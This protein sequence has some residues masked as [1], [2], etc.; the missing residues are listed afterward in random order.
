[1]KRY[2]LDNA[3]MI[4]RFAG[5]NNEEMAVALNRVYYHY[6]GDNIFEIAGIEFENNYQRVLTRKQI[7]PKDKPQEK[8][9]ADVQQLNFD[10]VM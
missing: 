7:E 2:V 3:R 10:E 5:L 4:L 8:T 9:K 1:M 6:S